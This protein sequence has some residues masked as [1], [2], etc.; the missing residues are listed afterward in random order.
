MPWSLITINKTNATAAI[1]SANALIETFSK[2]CR[3]ANAVGPSVR[4]WHKTKEPT[5]HYFLFSPVA[6]QAAATTMMCYGALPF[7]ERPDL[8]GFREIP[9]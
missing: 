5:V 1:M 7:D 2:E 4:V 6:T 9:I 8:T 3:A